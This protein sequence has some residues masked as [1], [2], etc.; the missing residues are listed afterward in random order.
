MDVMN[1]VPPKGAAKHDLLF[2]E[3]ASELGSIRVRA[4]FGER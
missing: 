4:M 1:S 3:P 2:N